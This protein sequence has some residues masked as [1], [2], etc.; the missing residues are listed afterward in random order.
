MKNKGK[1]PKCG[2][3]GILLIAGGTGAYGAG[4]NILLG[5]TAFSAVPVNRYLCSQCGYS[6]EWVDLE[7]LSKLKKK[8]G[9]R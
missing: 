2:G 3:S 8:Y 9:E 4:N 6:E 7:H 5:S 1:C